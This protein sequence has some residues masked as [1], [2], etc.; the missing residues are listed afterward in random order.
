M[1]VSAIWPTKPRLPSTAV[2]HTPRASLWRQHE[3]TMESDSDD[4]ES[5]ASVL[6]VT[7]RQAC[8]SHDVW[9]VKL[10]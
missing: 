7:L 6:T 2:P 4:V 3:P 9:K 8:A 10:L 5:I 1:L